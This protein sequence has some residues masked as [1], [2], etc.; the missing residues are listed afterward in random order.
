MSN[1]DRHLYH[2]IKPLIGLDKC[3]LSYKPF[4]SGARVWSG[5]GNNHNLMP[6]KSPSNGL[7]PTSLASP[8]PKIIEHWVIE[9]CWVIL[10]LKHRSDKSCN[11]ENRG[12]RSHLTPGCHNLCQSG[13]DRERKLRENEEMERDILFSVFSIYAFF[14]SVANILT[15]ALWGNTSGSKQPARKPYNWCRPAL[16]FGAIILALFYGRTTLKAFSV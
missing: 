13:R 7:P 5:E 3:A 14:A 2:I 11:K 4:E 10:S 8:P 9:S 12:L 16:P 15:Y 6:P 1:Q